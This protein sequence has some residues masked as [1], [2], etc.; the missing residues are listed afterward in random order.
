L[1]GP[2]EVLA[3]LEILAILAALSESFTAAASMKL[4]S[5][6]FSGRTSGY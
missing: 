3:I 6:T 2:P 5:D 4:S 1:L